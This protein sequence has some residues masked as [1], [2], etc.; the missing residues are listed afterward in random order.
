MLGVVLSH[1]LS[2][3]LARGVCRV[4]FKTCKRM[5]RGWGCCPQRTRRRGTALSSLS[6][7]QFW[8]GP[9]GDRGAPRNRGFCYSTRLCGTDS[10]TRNWKIEHDIKIVQKSQFTAIFPSMAMSLAAKNTAV[11]TQNT[12]RS[13]VQ[14]PAGNP[15]LSAAPTRCGLARS[16]PCQRRGHDCAR[17]AC[18]LCLSP[19]RQPDS[20]EALPPF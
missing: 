17:P 12:L 16:L 7:H 10:P 8:G 1:S 4:F 13:C 2:K 9:G 11:L 19:E 15:T 18:A 3:K 6:Q 20:A 5:A 14:W